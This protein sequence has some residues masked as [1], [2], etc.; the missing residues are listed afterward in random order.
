MQYMHSRLYTNFFLFPWKFPEEITVDDQCSSITK[1][2]IYH[3]KHMSIQRFTMGVDWLKI[4]CLME[5]SIVFDICRYCV[6]TFYGR[7]GVGDLNSIFCS[8]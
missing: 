5:V 8:N 3:M 1:G 4:G 6:F 2:I 7:Y